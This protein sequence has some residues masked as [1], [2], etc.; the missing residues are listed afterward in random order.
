MVTLV[1]LMQEVQGSIPGATLQNLGVFGA[2]PSPQ[3]AY[4]K[5]KWAMTSLNK[6]KEGVKTWGAVWPM[7]CKN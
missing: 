3:K 1:T 6:V 4:I 5:S 2:Q 7:G